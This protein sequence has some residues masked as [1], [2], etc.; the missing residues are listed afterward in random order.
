MIKKSF[1]AYEWFILGHYTAIGRPALL[2]LAENTSSTFD[3][4]NLS[5][6]LGTITFNLFVIILFN[7]RSITNISH[8]FEYRTGEREYQS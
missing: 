6:V 8:P 7:T 5:F 2:S 4:I 3:Q 1:L